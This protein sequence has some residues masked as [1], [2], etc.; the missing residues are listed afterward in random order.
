WVTRRD[1]RRLSV[2]YA[3]VLGLAGSVVCFY[4]MSRYR[5]PIMPVVILFAA[6]A[7]VGIPELARQSAR[8]WTPGIALVLGFVVLTNLPVRIP[9]DDTKLNLGT[10]LIQ[11]ERS[12]EAVPLLKAAIAESPQYAPPHFNLA[13]AYAA[14]GKRDE[15]LAEYQAAVMLRPGDFKAQEAL[16]IALQEAG[17][18]GDALEHFR[19]A[20]RL[21][22]N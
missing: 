11:L 14:L 8:R 5:Y 18:P 19:E 12:E 16:A 7:L 20:A 17:K 21:Q 6:A 22:P 2:L 9:G 15:A 13:V 4:V 3:L 10:E 1:W